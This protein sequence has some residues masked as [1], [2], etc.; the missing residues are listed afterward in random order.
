MN[1]SP[2]GRAPAKRVRGQYQQ[3]DTRM[4][5]RWGRAPAKRVRGQ[6]GFKT[7]KREA[8]YWIARA[9]SSSTLAR[10]ASIISEE[11]AQRENLISCPKTASIS[12]ITRSLP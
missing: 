4:K 9:I 3:V 5:I 10:T 12:A 11:R 6:S 2:S 1:G 8:Y 7:S